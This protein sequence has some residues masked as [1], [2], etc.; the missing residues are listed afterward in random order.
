[1]SDLG[2][3]YGVPANDL[4]R[5]AMA[6]SKEAADAIRLRE[7]AD[8]LAS[9]GGVLA[10][11]EQTAAAQQVQQPGPDMAPPMEA[12]PMGPSDQLSSMP[13]QRA[14]DAMELAAAMGAGRRMSTQINPNYGTDKA[15]IDR[16]RELAME[17]PDIQEQ[18]YNTQVAMARD[19]AVMQDQAHAAAARTEMRQQFLAEQ[20]AR[21]R[22]DVESNLAKYQQAADKAAEEF[23]R[24]DKFD[25]GQAWA[26]KSVGTKI[27]ISLAALGRGLQG[28]N[29][30]EV[31]NDVLQ[32]ELAA[33]RQMRSDAGETLAAARGS[34]ASALNQRDTF[35]ALAQ[36][37]RTADALT[38]AATLRKIQAKMAAMEAEYGPQIVTDQWLEAR[39]AAE[40]MLAET[41][42]RLDHLENANWRKR[43][44]MVDTMDPETRRTLGMLRDEA[45]KSAGDASRDMSG[46]QRD[47]AK[48]EVEGQGRQALARE[49]ENFDQKKWLAEKTDMARTRIGLIDKFTSKYGDDIPG[50]HAM[51]R[52]PLVSPEGFIT[53]QFEDNR[54]SMEQ[55]KR[56][57]M[58]Q[59]REESGQ[60]TTETEIER[61]AGIIFNAMG[62]GDVRG[63]LRRM[64]EEAE[65][66]I[67]NYTHATSQDAESEYL[68]RPVGPR[69]AM[70]R[71]APSSEPSTLVVDE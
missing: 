18:Q 53:R 36:D 44:V 28:G 32:R 7:Q 25:P 62:E 8:S 63:K 19:A 54:E 22:A 15:L 10:R 5:A 60:G 68:A 45:V 11:A 24:A 46:L 70:T 39:N 33:H 14:Q 2:E 59:V 55:L 57:I 1:M 65:A 41:G 61:E 71:G 35:L 64:R 27:R 58:L 40:Q 6:R 20:E 13:G 23:A 37:E 3:L 47:L 42:N 30:Q 31:F 9:Q 48:S 52:L 26:D 51:S 43:Q 4:Q 38:E 66:K 16:S 21:K 69:Q 17:R 34:A 49:K 50:I 56:I 29:P 67:Q 12:A